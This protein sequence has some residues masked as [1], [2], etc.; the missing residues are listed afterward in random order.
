[1]SAALS[2][3]DFRGMYHMKKLALTA[4]ALLATSNLA[5]AE[6]C[7]SAKQNWQDGNQKTCADIG[8]N[9]SIARDGSDQAQT[10]PPSTPVVEPVVVT[11]FTSAI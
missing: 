2:A 9:V 4:L 6:V 10:P 11:T 7:W 5:S 3:F 1:M 8:R